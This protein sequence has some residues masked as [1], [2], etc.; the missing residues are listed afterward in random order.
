MGDCCNGNCSKAMSTSKPKAP[1]AKEGQQIGIR[2]NSSV[3]SGVIEHKK[4]E[5][6]NL[7]KEIVADREGVK[8]Y[9]DKIDLLQQRKNDL[10]K[11]IE[12]DKVFCAHFDENIGPFEREYYKC[13]DQVREKYDCAKVAYKDSLQL[14]IKEFGFH[15]AYKRWH[16]EF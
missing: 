13:Q 6:A 5:I 11:Q 2:N 15:P 12:Q 7:D 14:L 3:I 16:D 10:L 1:K 9:Q 8:E 4:Q